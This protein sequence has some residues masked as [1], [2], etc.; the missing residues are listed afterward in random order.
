MLTHRTI[1]EE[2]MDGDDLSPEIYAAVLH[3][4]SQANTVT[5]ARRPTLQFLDKVAARQTA[6]HVPIRILDVGFGDG[7]MLRSIS[8]WSVRRRR[9]VTLVG[10]DLNPR[11][12]PT[13]IAATPPG[14]SID[15]RTGDY[16][17]LASQ[18]WDAIVSSLVAHHMSHEELIAFLRFMNRNAMAGWFVNDLRRHI[19]AQ[20]GFRVLARLARWHPIVRHDGALS[21]A[22]SYRPE[23][24][25]PILAEAAVVDARVR[26][27]FPYRL[28][29]ECLR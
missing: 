19:V 4:L 20:A 22:R 21:V 14:V 12:A 9:P 5:L 10:I 18:P 15:Y 17:E 11:S 8:R 6:H 2:L 13:A 25:P 29:V 23:E 16:A 3:D 24:W 28:C 26:M 1:A 7:D 27:F